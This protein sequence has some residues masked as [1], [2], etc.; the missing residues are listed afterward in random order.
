MSTTFER[1]SAKAAELG[2]RCRAVPWTRVE[3]LR[4]AIEGRFRDGLLDEKALRDYLSFIYQAPEG[5]EPRSI[6][7]VAFQALPGRVNFGWRGGRVTVVIPPTYVGFMNRIRTVVGTL[8]DWLE[9]EGFRVA[10][11][12]LPIKTLAVCSGLAEYGRNN[13]C[14]VEGLGSYL[15]LA[16][17][18]SDMPCD[19]D[20]WREP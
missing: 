5:F 20:P 4:E 17:A 2:W 8:G 1:I 6:I 7:V 15:Q 19:S 16:V 10:R 3:Y 13:V 12:R 11:P 18:A 9:P 14:Y